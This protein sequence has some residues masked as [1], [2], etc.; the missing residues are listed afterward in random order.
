MLDRKRFMDYIA[1]IRFRRTFE[2]R[3]TGKVKVMNRKS[4]YLLR[5]LAASLAK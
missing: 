5:T 2:A 3:G 1:R 4:V